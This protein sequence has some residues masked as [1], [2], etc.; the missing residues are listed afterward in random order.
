MTCNLTQIVKYAV[1]YPTED[2]P[3]INKNEHN[4]ANIKHHIIWKDAL[5]LKAK[6]R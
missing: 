2:Q 6:G 5:A 3:F 4:N 1:H